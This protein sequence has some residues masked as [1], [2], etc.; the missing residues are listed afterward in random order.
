MEQR[1]K[2][3]Y[4]VDLKDK[5]H[6]AGMVA[7][8]VGQGKRVL[9]IGAGPGSITR[10]L[11]GAQG[12]AVTAVE[13]DAEALPYLEPHCEQVFQHDLNDPTWLEGV[14][15][16]DGYD[17]IV[18]TDVLEHLL[19]PWATLAALK[20]LL[21]PEGHVV[22][23]LPHSGHHAV[24]AALLNGDFRYHPWGLLDRTHIRFF[25]LQNIYD[26][27]TDAGFAIVEADY[28]RHAP[29]A[30]ELA[31]LWHKLP[32]KMRSA[33]RNSAHGD[34]YQV[35]I[36]A[37]PQAPDVQGLDCLAPP[38]APRPPRHVREDLKAGLRRWLPVPIRHI[39]VR[40]LEILRIKT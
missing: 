17:A 32:K 35:V 30:T 18:A 4:S 39:L 13:I 34:I 16:P 22:I 38:P 31:D 23:S 6:V 37:R 28:V 15:R 5:N 24:I 29:E 36:K 11:K 26:L 1:H 14:A 40:L 21:A 33:L 27:F 3:E 9:E 25:C 7:R 8:M 2:Y 12:C 20:P 19:D 10:H